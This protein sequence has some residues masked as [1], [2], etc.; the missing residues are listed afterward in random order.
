MVNRRSVLALGGAGALAGLAGCLELVSGSEAEFS[1]EPVA[2]PEATLGETGYEVSERDRITVEEPVG[3]GGV[4]RRIVVHNE[5]VEYVKQVTIGPLGEEDAAVFTALTSPQVRIMGREFNPIAEM[6]S[7]ELAD[8]LAE[9]Y[10]G[11]GSLDH[12][13]DVDSTAAGEQTTVGRF[14]TEA[15]FAGIEEAIDVELWISQPVELD[16]DLLITVGA[17]PTLVD[18]R[19]NVLALMDAVEPAE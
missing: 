15:T 17:Y 4:D 3:A 2:V 14:E 18:E 19:E 7:A 8:L 16:D 9:S 10:D 6:D 1:A 12:Q 13:E 5:L 11:F